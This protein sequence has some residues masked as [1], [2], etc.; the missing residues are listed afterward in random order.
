MQLEDRLGSVS[1]GAIQTT[2]E[3][4][5]FPHK[6]K[7]V[8]RNSNTH[9]RQLLNS[10]RA[11][12]TRDRLLCEQRKPL[13]LKI[14]DEE[15]TDVDEKCTICLSMLEDGEDVRSEKRVV[16]PESY[17]FSLLIQEK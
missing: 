15:E 1:R 8:G 9:E 5:T 12:L 16:A 4:F 2:I 7:K 11:F 17:F 6:Y 3:R 13:Q 14:G 10:D